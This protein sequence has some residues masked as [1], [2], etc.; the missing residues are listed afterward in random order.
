MDKKQLEIISVNITIHQSLEFVWDTWNDENQMK[1]W[2]FLSDDYE[3]TNPKNDLRIGGGY[4]YLMKSKEG[5]FDF[6]YKATYKQI[7]LKKFIAFTLS[8][9]RRVEVAFFEV[10]DVVHIEIRFEAV[11]EQDLDVQL[12]G[13]QKLL[14]NFKNHIEN[15]GLL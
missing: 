4:S 7:E 11:R 14:F 1:Y 6:E 10:E 15:Q 9:S 3:I 8:D 2:L 5:G 13:W 12:Q